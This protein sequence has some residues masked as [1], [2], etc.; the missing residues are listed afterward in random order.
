M[1]ALTVGKLIEILQK[2]PPEGEVWVNNYDNSDLS[3]PVIDC[4]PLNGGSDIL[5]KIDLVVD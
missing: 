1:E 5:L 3:N 2:F 4:I